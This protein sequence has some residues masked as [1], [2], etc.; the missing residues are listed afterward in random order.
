MTHSVLSHQQRS[1]TLHEVL[2]LHSHIHQLHRTN[3]FGLETNTDHVSEVERTVSNTRAFERVVV[4]QRA[5]VVVRRT[6]FITVRDVVTLENTNSRHSD[7]FTTRDR[8]VSFRVEIAVDCVGVLSNEFV[9]LHWR[10]Q[11]VA[12]LARHVFAV[13]EFCHLKD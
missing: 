11:D 3:G 5:V 10:H 6:G 2:R 1:E 9:I 4:D 12:S 13:H 7:D 8:P